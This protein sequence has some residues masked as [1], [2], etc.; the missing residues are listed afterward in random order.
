MPPS[1]GPLGGNAF[2][3][4]HVGEAKHPPLA[5]QLHHD[6]Q[7]RQPATTTRKRKNHACAKPDSDI[8]PSNGSVIT[9]H[10]RPG[11]WRPASGP[12]PAGFD[13]AD[14]VGDPV[15]VGAQRHQRCP[16]AADGAGH[17]GAVGRGR[18]G[19]VVTQ[20]RVDG[21]LAG[22]AGFGVLQDDVADVGQLD[23]AGV[24]HLD[25]EHLVP[26]RDR[27]QRT[28]PV[29][30]AEEV[31]DDH[32]HS[33]AA[34][35]PAQRV[36]GRRQIPAHPDRRLGHGG[37]GAQQRLLV[38][39]SGACRHPG[40][41]HA[42]GDQGADPVAAAAV[43]VGDRGRGGHRQV[44][45]LAAGG[46]EVQA[47]RHVD[48]HPGL[49]FAVGDHLPDMR[50]GG[51]RGHRPVHPADVV[52]GLI[53]ARL[54]RLR[55]GTRDQAEMVAVQDT[56]EL[57]FDRELERAQRRRQL[58]VVDLPALHR[59]R[60]Q[61][62]ALRCGAD[63]VC[64]GHRPLAAP[65]ACITGPT[66]WPCWGTAFTCGRATVCRIRLMTISGEISSASAS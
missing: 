35:G 13:E 56:V 60:M 62:A 32:R 52:A 57:A 50:V 53:L 36:D 28:H 47:G 6:V 5:R 9:S 21:E 49:Q 11:H 15:P 44:A 66:E 23:V 8:G 54:P 39:T 46:A 48:H 40:R 65:A 3:Q 24:E 7:R 63:G 16:A 18:L 31:A 42:V 41:R 14:D 19:E 51:A 20:L 55:T 43:E 30:R 58:R 33:A 37:D 61:S 45:L 10:I 1:R 64:I 59:R 4:L 38:L 34:F 29:D 12:A 2:Q 25:A 26:G 22:D 27:A 17:F